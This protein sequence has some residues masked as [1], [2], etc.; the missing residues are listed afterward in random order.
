MELTVICVFAAGWVC[1]KLASDW[2]REK[3]KRLAREAKRR[4]K[5]DA[6]MTQEMRHIV[7]W[8]QI[9]R[10]GKGEEKCQLATIPSMKS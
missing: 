3:K 10:I 4:M 1:K 7:T 5:A 9:M 8:P 6:A 2:Y